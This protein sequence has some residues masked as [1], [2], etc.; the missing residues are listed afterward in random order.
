MKNYQLF[1]P[2]D[3]VEITLSHSDD[4]G[5]IGTIVEVR[6]SFCVID[7]GRYKQNGKPW[8]YNHTYGQFRLWN[9]KHIIKE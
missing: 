6:H 1:H 9:S 8:Y 2:G 3:K 4:C 5:K 7:C